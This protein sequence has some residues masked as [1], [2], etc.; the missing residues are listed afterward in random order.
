MDNLNPHPQY[1][2]T[3]FFALWAVSVVLSIVFY[4]GSISSVI[5]N[6]LN[7]ACSTTGIWEA[8]QTLIQPANWFG[9]FTLALTVIGSIQFYKAARSRWN[10]LEHYK[11][12]ALITLAAIILAVLTLGCD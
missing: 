12:L 8:L 7:N 11:N 2:Q 3:G 1:K 4:S 9:L 10:I 6:D 5:H